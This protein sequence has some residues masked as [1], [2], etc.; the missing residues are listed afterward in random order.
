[1]NGRREA[2]RNSRRFV[3]DIATNITN[4]SSN[5][6]AITSREDLIRDME[7]TTIHGP[8]SADGTTRP[9]SRRRLTIRH[10][11]KRQMRREKEESVCVA[12]QPFLA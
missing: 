5:A 2:C 3:D 10:N 1:M 6:G 9:Y 12:L 4:I 7:R 11:Y 8:Q